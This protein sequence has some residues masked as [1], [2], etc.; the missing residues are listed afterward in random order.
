MAM[1]TPHAVTEVSEAELLAAR[2][3]LSESRADVDA[4][5]IAELPPSAIYRAVAGHYERGWP[6][7]QRDQRDH[8]GMPRT[9]PARARE[10][11]TPPDPHTRPDDRLSR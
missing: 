6:Q 4:E 2:R 11:L 5:V 10:H 7:F 8:H 3:W 9:T 1:M